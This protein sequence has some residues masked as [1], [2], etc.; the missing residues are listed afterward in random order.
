MLS[1]CTYLEEYV[2]F[3]NVQPEVDHIRV[4]LYSPQI[5]EQSAERLTTENWRADCSHLA[6]IAEDLSENSSFPKE[7]ARAFL[8]R[9]TSPEDCLLRRRR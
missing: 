7:K 6:I 3:G 1:R 8:R 2:A 9:R 5:G 4:S